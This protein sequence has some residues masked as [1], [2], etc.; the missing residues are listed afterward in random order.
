MPESKIRLSIIVVSHFRH[1]ALLRLYSSLQMA[2]AN[3]NCTAFEVLTITNGFDP[4]MTSVESE[5][6]KFS[7]WTF[8]HLERPVS[9]PQARNVGIEM[10]QGEWVVFLDDDVSVPADYFQTFF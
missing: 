9:P 2:L 7:N 3:A 1:Q 6:L 5:W 10:A 4:E 8:K